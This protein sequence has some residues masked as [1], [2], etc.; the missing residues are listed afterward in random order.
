MQKEM[1]YN[2]G[3]SFNFW[4]FHNYLATVNYMQIQSPKLL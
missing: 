4:G 2:P 1:Y 3:G